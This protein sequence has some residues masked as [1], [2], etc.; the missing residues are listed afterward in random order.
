M[1]SISILNTGRLRIWF[2]YPVYHKQKQS[3]SDIPPLPDF[4]KINARGSGYIQTSYC[5]K[6]YE[7]SKFTYMQKMKRS[8]LNIVWQIANIK[9]FTTLAG[10]MITELDTW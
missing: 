8:H 2:Y 10:H 3:D 5:H 4:F 9:V 1:W 6:C 7:W